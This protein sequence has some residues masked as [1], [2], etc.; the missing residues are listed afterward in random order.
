MPVENKYRVN[1]VA[2]DF[3]LKNKDITDILAKY[4]T[5]PKNHMTALSDDELSII[6][7]CLTQ[8][9]A[10]ESFEKYFEE[11][12][13]KAAEAKPEVKE[14]PAP[15]VK[16]EVKEETKKEAQSATSAKDAKANKPAPAK[17]PENKQ[18][19]VETQTIR[20]REVRYVDTRTVHVDLSKYDER[21]ETF[22]SDKTLNA[23]N[24]KQKIK[25]KNDNKQQ[26]SSKS[27]AE[28]AEKMRRL[29]LE[30]KKKKLQ[31]VVIPEELQVCELAAKLSAT[32]AEVIKKLMLIGVM[33]SA[34]QVIDYDTACLIAE[35]FGAKV[36]KEVVVTIEDKLFDVTED[37]AEELCER[38]PVVVVMGHVDHGKT[39]IL[40]AIRKTNVT[41]GEAGG[42]TQHIGAYRVNAQGKDITFLDTPGHAAF[43]A[44]R[45]RG[46]QVTDIAIIVVAADDGIM[47]QTVEAINHAKAAGVSI[48]V[49]INKM[50][51]PTA[52]P[53]R[54][55]QALTE[56]DLIVEDWGG[57]V[58]AVPC[59]A[60]TG[61]N[62][63]KL[64]ENVLLIAELKELKANPNRTAKGTVIEARLDKGRGPV[65][66]VLV[67]N[68]TLKNGDIL[69]AGTAVGRVRAMTDDKGKKVAEA[70]PSVPVEIIGL[71]EVPMAGDDFYVVAD[72]RMARELA[73]QRKHK[74]KESLSNAAS[75]IVSL[76]DLFNQIQ[77]GEVKEL[78]VI[79]KSD[80]Q[81]TFEAVKAS[82]EKLSNSE[83][84][85]RVIHGGVGAV[86]ESDV[87]LA[88]ASGAIIVGFN[89]RPEAAAT[90][91]AAKN[92]VDIRLYRVIYDC[93][94]EIQA[95]MKGML[96][97]KFKEEILGH[98][99]I[100]QTFKV[101][102]VG[103]IAGTMVKDGKIQ[104]NSLVRLLRDNIVVF[105]GKLAS[106]KRFKDDAKEVAEGYECGIGLENFNDIKEGDVIEAYIM[107]EIK[108]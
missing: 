43:T 75:K 100:R 108:D 34:N 61:M 8:K 58:I 16:A 39:S 80:V 31:H 82:L 69:I 59:S 48:I 79:V 12:N 98:A 26:T 24:Q 47:P 95:A 41:A 51:K 3:N 81:G 93:L 60:L 18:S 96:A 71:A 84:R 10:I 21:L 44:M 38:A 107:Q 67:Q 55:K 7:D 72:E 46:A 50:D 30:K 103:T 15:E 74:A 87:M 35:E 89:V 1:E 86:S 13:K 5:A 101:S 68:G 17:Q 57:D 19:G 105:D 11:L 76:D 92:K 85:V 102:G 66:T 99:E 27:R 52:N 91:Y 78:P 6:F 106:L 77:E 4:A 64:L 70:G 63:D 42:I 56:Y 25:K 53:E 32:N 73:D 37:G 94:E 9:N 22:V 49:A 28:E 90:A 29:M 14:E 62:I 23:S 104:R 2:K 54:V 33:A 88:S 36:T 20:S 40:D 97:P 45:A 83:V 65:T